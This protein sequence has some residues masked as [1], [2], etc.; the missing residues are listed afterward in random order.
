MELEFFLEKNVIFVLKIKTIIKNKNRKIKMT[1]YEVTFNE[2][3]A[4]G[5]NFLAFLVANKKYVKVKNPTEMT[6][7]EFDAMIEES[8]EQ[9]RQGKYKTI[10]DV[11]KFLQEL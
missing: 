10:D 9:Y 1:T 3:T 5:K 2:K 8:R 6:E 4:F 11:D 7:E